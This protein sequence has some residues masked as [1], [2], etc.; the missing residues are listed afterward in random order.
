LTP[1]DR[2]SEELFHL[3][4]RDEWERAV[5]GGDD[6]YR[7]ST[8]GRSLEEVGFIHCSFRE[9]AQGVADLFYAGRDDVVLLCIDIALVHAEVR[10]EN[11]DGGAIL[12]PHVYGP[13]PLSA[14]KL[15]S[16][17]SSGTDGRLDVQRAMDN[18]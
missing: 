18:G 9:Q 7:R 14:V 12:F 6:D 11:L 15:V 17:V 10:V 1:R 16:S 13:L 3:A 2:G 8:I 4:L 5:A